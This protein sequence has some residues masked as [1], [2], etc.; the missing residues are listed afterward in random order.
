MESNSQNKES[1]IE[2]F[3]GNIHELTMED[4]IKGGK[5]TSEKKTLA[6]LKKGY[7][8]G[9]CL[10]C[11][12][13]QN[14][15]FVLCDKHQILGDF[16]EIMGC[17]N[18]EKIFNMVLKCCINLYHQGEYYKVASLLMELRDSKF[19]ELK[20]G[21]AKPS[22]EMQKII[23]DDRDSAFRIFHKDFTEEIPVEDN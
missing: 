20:Y 7:T 15:G 2:N 23:D 8:N 13:A 1:K 9:I 6:N 17:H 21:F 12:E 14:E 11:M 19:P 5:A 16:I 4:R 3:K 18:P 22:E 10:K